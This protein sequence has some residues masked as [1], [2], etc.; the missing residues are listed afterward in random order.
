MSRE[1]GQR[2]GLVR[3]D[4]V[5]TVVRHAVAIGRRGLGCADVE[6]PVDLP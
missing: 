1:V 3:L 4:E 6:A 5:E 2:E